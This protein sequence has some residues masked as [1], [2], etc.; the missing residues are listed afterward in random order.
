MSLNYY[1]N[2]DDTSKLY[3]QLDDAVEEI[4]QLGKEIDI[5]KNQYD[6]EIADIIKNNKN[7]LQE[8]KD[9]IEK[10][11]LNLIKINSEATG[12]I[13][14]LFT[15]CRKIEQDAFDLYNDVVKVKFVELILAILVIIL[16]FI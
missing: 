5:M 15:R 13:E 1:Y 11:Y 8:L 7:E 12:E 3:N 16:F 2:N 14:K 9:K 10:D 4:Y 6:N